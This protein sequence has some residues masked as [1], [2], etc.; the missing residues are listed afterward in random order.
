M[1]AFWGFPLSNAFLGG[2]AY[3]I[4]KPFYASL[5]FAKLIRKRSFVLD[6]FDYF[7]LGGVLF[8]LATATIVTYS[9]T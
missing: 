8:A 7:Y 3:F 2:L 1:F 9:R 5:Y 4:C 6:S